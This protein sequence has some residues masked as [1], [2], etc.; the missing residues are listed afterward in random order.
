MQ[1][2]RDRLTALRDRIRYRGRT[3]RAIVALTTAEAELL[4]STYGR[5]RAPISVIPNGVDV[6]RFRPPAAGERAQARAAL[7]IDDERTVAV[8][9]GHEFER[10][11]LPIAIDAL[12]RARGVTLVVVGG[13]PEMIRRAETHAR[14][15]GV[16]DRVVFAGTHE[17]P[18]P[19]LHA[20]DLLCPVQLT[21]EWR[22]LVYRR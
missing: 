7:G 20:A 21:G 15:V 8:F 14:A 9:V 17:D 1:E 5:V 6:E 12:A 3:H 18:V 11:G 16:A 10:K 22:A 19:F 2:L 13:S 4:V